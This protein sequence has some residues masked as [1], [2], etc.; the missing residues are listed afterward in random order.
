MEELSARGRGTLIENTVLHIKV[1]T[2]RNRIYI[3]TKGR[4]KVAGII[5]AAGQII[6]AVEHDI[7]YANFVGACVR[8]ICV[9]ENATLC[10]SIKVDKKKKKKEVN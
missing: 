9:A 2:K 3:Y 10:N 5:R 6:P 4:Q 8:D 1:V 7:L